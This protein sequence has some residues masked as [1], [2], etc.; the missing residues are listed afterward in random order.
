MK[1]I[2]IKLEAIKTMQIT[3]ELQ[4]IANY[5]VQPICIDLHPREEQID[6]LY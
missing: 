4:N 6:Q 5:V 1:E 3:K 2:T